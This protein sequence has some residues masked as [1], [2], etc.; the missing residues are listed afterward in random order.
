M[1]R[2]IIIGGGASGL[3]AAIMAARKS[4]KAQIILLEQKD[5]PGK[6]I[7]ATGNGRCNLTNLLQN[8][9]CY[10]SEHPEIAEN[11]LARFPVK[12]TLAFFQ[13]LGLMF[14]MR[15]DYVYPRSDQASTVLEL[16]L[17]E[18]E[19]LGVQV[20]T[21]ISVDSVTRNAKGF[22][23]SAKE[24]KYLADAVILA[25]GG[26]ASSAL[27]SDGSGYTLAKSLGHSMEPVVPALV[28][29]K[30]AKHP[31]AKA[32]GV[33]TEATVSARI[34]GEI[35]AS[36]RGELQITAY[37]ISGIPVFQVSRYVAKGLYEKRKVQ[38]QLDLIPDLEQSEFVSYLNRRRTGRESMA[39]GEFLTGIFH[40]K[41][42][43]RLLEQAGIRMNQKFSE[44]TKQQ[45]RHFADICKA[46]L[47]TITDT[48]G[49]ENAQVC[50]GGVPLTEIHPDTMESKYVPGLYLTGELLDVDGICGGY[51]LQWAWTTGALAGCACVSRD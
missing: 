19:R 9:S 26:K 39:C 21:G 33:R 34:D 37:G 4:Q 12:D 17:L 18:A 43:P 42:I 6:K 27:G 41:L 2:V 38:V 48:N 32:S 13:S 44:L 24:Q 20:H 14:K 22:R 51:N 40:K 28:Q 36:D 8:P 1:K 46:G 50:A 49:F 31:Y 23:V 35:V 11:I 25:C 15:G 30:V 10:R 45:V 5:S 29:L 7:L 16:L 3:T 47:L